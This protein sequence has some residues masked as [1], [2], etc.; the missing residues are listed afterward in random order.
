MTERPAEEDSDRA[1]LRYYFKTPEELRGPPARPRPGG[2]LRDRG[3]LV[4]V[5]DIVILMLVFAILQYQGSLVR[6]DAPSDR[7]LEIGRLH[8]SGSFPGA[9]AD[10]KPR[11]YVALRNLSAVPIRFPGPGPYALKGWEIQ[12]ARPEGPRTICSRPVEAP[13]LIPPHGAGDITLQCE[14][15]AAGKVDITL[16]LLFAEGH[17]VLR[18]PTVMIAR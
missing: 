1:P 5:A 6:R 3:R 4:V 14:P 8:V 16:R 2:W 17:Q 9:T 13:I 10:T 15:I 12:F 18:F 7:T 11:L